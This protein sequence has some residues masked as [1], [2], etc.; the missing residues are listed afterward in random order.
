MADE[1][2]RRQRRIAVVAN[3]AFALVVADPGAATTSLV[4]GE[5]WDWG[6]FW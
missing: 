3:L 6:R 5:P 2:R 1:Q 4:V